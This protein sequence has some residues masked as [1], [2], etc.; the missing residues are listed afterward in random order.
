[1]SYY[2]GVD[3]GGTKTAAVILNAGRTEVGR[4]AGGACNIATGDDATLT[5]SIRAAVTSALAAAGLPLK[6]RFHGACAGVAGYTA[7][8][9]RREFQ[10]I[11]EETVTSDR[12]RV[13]PD[14]VIAYWGASAGEPGII[15]IA[16]T[17]TA[18][19]GRSADGKTKRVDGRGF[20][21]GDRGSGFDI[22]KQALV[23]TLR[24]LEATGECDEF[25][26]AILESIGG[27]ESDDVV[28][29]TYRPFDPAR[30][31]RLSE[32]VGQLAG[33]GNQTALTLV[34]NAAAVL[35][36]NV[37]AIMCSLEL[38]AEAPVF[39]LGGLWNLGALLKVPFRIGS[40]PASR[41]PALELNL[42]DARHDAAFG[43]A[44]MAAS[45]QV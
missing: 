4:G 13:E 15:V 30:I 38:P 31:A 32:R 10:R 44:L 45:L 35:R 19:F 29:W 20:L 22:G 37:Q 25:G 16:G 33:H 43:A 3:G 36:S 40:A 42:C 7:K 39:T 11:F 23:I 2:L 28:E 5:E 34:E 9:R 17:G 27:A 8:I 18:A 26:R 21:L 41:G 24:Q 1:M 12:Y 6:T 14:Y